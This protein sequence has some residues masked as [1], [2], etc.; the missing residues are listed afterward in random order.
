MTKIEMDK[1]DV[2]PAH[3]VTAP[4]TVYSTSR[5]GKYLAGICDH[6]T[7]LSFW[8]SQWGREIEVKDM[9]SARVVDVIYTRATNPGGF[10]FRR[11]VKDYLAAN[12]PIPK[13]R[14]LIDVLAELVDK[15][16]S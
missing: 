2:T 8:R 9:H 11:A 14:P 6:A 4:R 13:G 10:E 15:D 3:D 12:Q 7:G 16:S 1:A 5:L